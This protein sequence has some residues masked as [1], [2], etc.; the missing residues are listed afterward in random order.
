ML[1]FNSVADIYDS[2]E[3]ARARLRRTLDGLSAEAED[4]RPAPESWTIAE[5]VEHLSLVEGQISRLMSKVVARVEADGGASAGDGAQRTP[6][7]DF[8]PLAARA[9]EKFNAP[10]TARP[11][12]GVRVEESLARLGA[13]SDAIRALRPRVE[14][15]DLSATRLPHPAFGQLDF[16]QWL[17]VLGIHEE[18]HRRQIEAVKD[19]MNGRAAPQ[20]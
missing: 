20:T 2:L 12:G 11:K 7:V 17:A 4:F 15:L 1:T 6:L 5:I 18:R 19:T 16:Y 14:S 9:E 8:A 13:S 3:R 10:E